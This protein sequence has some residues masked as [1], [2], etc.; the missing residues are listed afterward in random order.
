MKNYKE[1]HGKWRVSFSENILYFINH[2][3]IIQLSVIK[4]LDDSDLIHVTLELP[5]FWLPCISLNHVGQ[6]IQIKLMASNKY[7]LYQI[8]PKFLPDIYV[9]FF[10]IEKV[11]SVLIF[12][13]RTKYHYLTGLRFPICKPCISF[14]FVFLKWNIIFLKSEIPISNYL[15]CY[16]VVWNIYK[17]LSHLVMQGYKIF[18]TRY[19]IPCFQ[20]IIVLGEASF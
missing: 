11:Y 7:D 18:E 3:R 1:W 17:I 8:Q 19:T 9:L 15:F 20:Y 16:A 5:S 10:V 2:L 4:S 14:R 6:E 13:Y 12:F